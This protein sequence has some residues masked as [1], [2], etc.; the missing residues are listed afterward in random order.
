MNVAKPVLF[1]VVLS[2]LPLA[3]AQNG[4]ASRSRFTG[5]LEPSDSVSGLATLVSV[6]ESAEGRIAFLRITLVAHTAATAATVHE[7]DHARKTS[8]GAPLAMLDLRKGEARSVV[9]R[10]A[11]PRDQESHLFYKVKARATDG[12]ISELT[13]Y[14]RIPSD[15]PN[16]C[17]AVDEYIQCQGAAVLAVEP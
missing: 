6:R 4:H 8:R 11:V 2:F 17:E 14:N 13:L 7:F 12:T 3:I 10:V 1:A 5:P 9:V 15:D 16:P